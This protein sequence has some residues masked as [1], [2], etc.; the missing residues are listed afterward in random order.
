ML[1]ISL[2]MRWQNFAT[3]SIALGY[4]DLRPRAFNGRAASHFG[5]GGSR[6]PC[7]GDATRRQP[8][9]WVLLADSY[10]VLSRRAR[11]KFPATR[12]QVDKDPWSASVG[13]GKGIVL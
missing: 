4:D 6:E 5:L 7:G 8:G 10:A 1:S 2:V 13:V 11:E 12:V 3:T 9:C